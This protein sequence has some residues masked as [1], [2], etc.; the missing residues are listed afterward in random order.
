[1]TNASTHSPKGTLQFTPSQLAGLK[2]ARND[3][4][5]FIL[6]YGGSRSGKSVLISWIVLMR[7]LRAAGT[8]HAI[9]RRTQVSCNST[10][11]D[12][13]FP[14]VMRMHDPDLWDKCKVNKSDS[15]IALPNGSTIHFG[16]LDDPVRRDKILGDEFATIWCNEV[17]EIDWDSVLLL[18]SRLNDIKDTLE[19]YKAG[20]RAGLAIKLQP[21]MFFDCNPKG[22]SAWEYKKFELGVNPKD[23]KPARDAEKWV[24]QQLNPKDNLANLPPDYLESMEDNYGAAEKRRF[25]DGYWG[26]ENA[27]PMFSQE[28]INTD[29]LPLPARDQFKR[30]VV[31][32]DPA[33]SA[34]EDSDLTGIV[35]AGVTED[36]HGWVLEDLSGRYSP[37]QWAHKVADAYHFWQADC[38]VAEKNQGG[39]LVETNL[40]TAHPDLPYKPI[41]AR[42]G[43]QVRAGP[44]AS[45]YERHRVSHAVTAKDP[46]HLDD[47]EREMTEYD[48][49]KK[50]AKSPDRLD[51]CVYALTEVMKVNQ[52]HRAAG[53]SSKLRGFW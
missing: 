31:A 34:N 27:N 49:E 6:Y 53:K 50:G 44:I 10:L 17:S 32:V 22:K 1:M 51:A 21:K 33:V 2:L 13:T 11:F 41:H 14:N 3:L 40:R 4:H 42:H 37:A 7:A 19:V 16:G 18:M 8:R 28:Q 30:I 20:E 38:V 26:D 47:L 12:L 5:K 35:V 24:C 9:F 45:L 15:I 36:D 43:K 52:K 39:N 29:R 48:P 46:D 25:I 23:G